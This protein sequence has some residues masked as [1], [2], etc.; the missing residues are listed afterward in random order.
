[1]DKLPVKDAWLA[2][3]HY[4]RKSWSGTPSSEAGPSMPRP[5]LLRPIDH[6]KDQ[7]YYLSSISEPALARALFPIAD[8]PKSEV[9][10]LA[11]RWELPTASRA[12]SMGLC[13]VGEKRHFHDW[14]C[15]EIIHPDHSCYVLTNLWA[16]QYIPPKPG[17]FID[18]TTGEVIG[19]HK[20]L[21]TF[22]IGQNARIRGLKEKMFVSRKDAK[23]N[24]I[25]VVPGRLVSSCFGFRMKYK[26][27]CVPT[28]STLPS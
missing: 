17:H 12:E 20:G 18:E 8:L 10:E 24:E 14:L 9:R 21:H 2:T 3:G 6:H 15:K 7:T 4:A 26:S 25:F 22:T 16:A 13:F 11:Q 27:L 19:E 28:A 5:K 23:T 1:M